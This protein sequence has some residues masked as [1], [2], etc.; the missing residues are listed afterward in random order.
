MASQ[1]RHRQTKGAETVETNLLSP[2][3]TSTLPWPRISGCYA[4]RLLV[5]SP[6]NEW[7]E[8]WQQVAPTAPRPSIPAVATESTSL[9][10]AGTVELAPARASDTQTAYVRHE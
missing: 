2:R 7:L 6:A 3:H 9:P 8:A 1:L 4:A 5:M 10:G